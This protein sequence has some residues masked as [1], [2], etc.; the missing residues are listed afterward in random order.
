MTIAE[1]IRDGARRLAAAGIEEP[2]RE[3]RLLLALAIGVD[4]GI[5]IGYPERVLDAAAQDKVAA[6][7]ER[8]VMREPVSRIVGQRQ[9]WSLNLEISPETLDPRPDSE[10]VIE[11]ALALLPDRAAPLRLLDLGTGSG[12][13]LLALM[14]ELPRATGTGIDLVPGAATMARRN[15]AATGFGD[16]TQFLAGYWGDAIAAAAADVILANPPYIPSGEL[17][18][19]APEV[20]WF[21]PRLAL[22]GGP[23]G[24]ESFRELA[25]DMHRLLA[26]DGIAIIEVGIGQAESVT[27]LLVNMG[28]VLRATRRDLAGIVRCVAVASVHQVHASDVGGQARYS[29]K[30]VGMRG[31]PV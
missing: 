27:E 12:A 15:A 18:G 5:V 9:F 29:K 22:D 10:T 2:R 3:A 16:R 13:L 28:L 25:E 4:P 14:S 1:A 23:D 19:L 21:E 11:T 7:V 20:A 31:F 24:L 26:P 6:F 8:R 30:L 17:P